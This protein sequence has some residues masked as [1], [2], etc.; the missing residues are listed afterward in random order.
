MK[1]QFNIS[2][3]L[4][5]IGSVLLFHFWGQ[6]QIVFFYSVRQFFFLLKRSLKFDLNWMSSFFVQPTERICIFFSYFVFICDSA[7][8]AV[9]IM[10]L[11][12]SQE[13]N[14]FV[15][16][17]QLETKLQFQTNYLFV[18]EWIDLVCVHITLRKVWMNEMEIVSIEHKFS[19]ENNWKL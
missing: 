5:F 2:F 19:I 6:I 11:W 8:S 15:H 16:S 18:Y 14:S 1:Y 17:D 4:I 3:N 10:I 7:L 9:V 12:S 13:M